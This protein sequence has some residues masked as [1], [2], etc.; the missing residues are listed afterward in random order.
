[1]NIKP[2]KAEKLLQQ[3]QLPFSL[4]A[5]T[6]GTLE[7]KL[8]LMSMFSSDSNAI[9]ISL[10]NVF[11]IFGPSLRVVSKDDSY[12]QEG[13]KELLEPYDEN[14]AFNIFSNNLKLRKKSR[15]KDN[16]DGESKSAANKDKSDERKLI[17]YP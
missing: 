15:S 16:V 7:L 14:N 1:M 10:E 8:S 3:L 12:L 11:F 2:S 9:H 13:E 17:Q 6:V 4:K 5:G